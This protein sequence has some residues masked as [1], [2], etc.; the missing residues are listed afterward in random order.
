MIST[1][2]KSKMELKVILSNLFLLFNKFGL[3]LDLLL[4][5]WGKGECLAKV[6][7]RTT[8]K[9][10]EKKKKKLQ[11]YL[12]MIYHLFSYLLVNR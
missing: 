1:F 4:P 12:F 6:V 9:K 7:L 3:L 8:I 11:I 10:T 2:I 5:Y